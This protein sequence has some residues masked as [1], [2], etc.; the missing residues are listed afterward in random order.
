M[1]ALWGSSPLARGLRTGPG[2]ARRRCRIIPARAGFTPWAPI[3]GCRRRDHPRSRGVYATAPGARAGSTGSSPLARG[4]LRT[5][6][7]FSDV[8]RIIPARAG[9]TSRRRRP[10]RPRADH[11]RSRGVYWPGRRARPPASGSSPLARGLRA[12]AAAVAFALGIIPARAGFTPVAVGRAPAD[13]GSSPLARGLLPAVRQPSQHLRII[14]ARAGF[15]PPPGRRSRDRSDH[16]RS[17]GVYVYAA[18]GVTVLAGSSPLA[19]GLLLG[20]VWEDG[21]SG[22]IPARAGFTPRTPRR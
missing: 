7:V 16:P 2:C 20:Y 15:T 12:R 17:R 10:Q 21:E 19:R 9:F 5:V 6:T 1:M 22:I 14:P 13:R 4:L 3:R 18:G 8:A 11:P